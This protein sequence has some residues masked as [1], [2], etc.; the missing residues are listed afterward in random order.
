MAEL[1]EPNPVMRWLSVVLRL[2]LAALFIYA[3]AIKVADPAA[4]AEA[5]RGY[6]V[7]PEGVLVA[8]TAFYLPWLEIVCGL[9]LL[10]PRY[11]RPAAGVVSLL[12]A[13][14]IVALVSAWWRGLDIECGCF[15]TAREASYPYLFG[16][17]L[18][19]LLAA[20]LIF[21]HSRPQ[22]FGDKEFGDVSLP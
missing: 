8:A 11:H 10:V 7:L 6:R 16:R 9:A 3:G 18:V 4:F 12:M 13:V 19:I 14:L 15:S 2:G 21:W 5:V 20:W 17:D 1:A 22:V